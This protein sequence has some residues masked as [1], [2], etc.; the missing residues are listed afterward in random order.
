VR[1]FTTPRR[2]YTQQR[3]IGARKVLQKTKKELQQI[4]DNLDAADDKDDFEQGFAML[5]SQGMPATLRAL[6][7]DMAHAIIEHDLTICQQEYGS[8]TK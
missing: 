2:K 8:P 6:I 1:P 7:L 5:E 4:Q 3:L